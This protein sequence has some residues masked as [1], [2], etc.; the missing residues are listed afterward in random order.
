MAPNIYCCGAGTAA[1]TEAVTGIFNNAYILLHIYI[2]FSMKFCIWLVSRFHLVNIVKTL[3]MWCFLL[4]QTWSAHSC[5]Y[6]A[7]TLV[8]NQELLQHWLF[9]RDTFSSWVSEL[10]FYAILFLV[11]TLILTLLNICSYQGHVSAALVLGGVDVTGPH[12]HTVS[13][14]SKLSFNI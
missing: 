10:M 14:L 8:E 3:K 4:L 6:I 2:S 7:T 13:S 1:D 11:C 5:N 9:L 12:L